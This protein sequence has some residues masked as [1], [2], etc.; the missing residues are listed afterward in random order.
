MDDDIEEEIT[1]SED[2]ESQ[3]LGDDNPVDGSHSDVETSNVIFEQTIH[4]TNSNKKHVSTSTSHTSRKTPQLSP[5][6]QVG[7]SMDENNDNNNDNN[8]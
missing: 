4:A 8:N 6:P 1:E 5:N 7:N 3:D 2:D